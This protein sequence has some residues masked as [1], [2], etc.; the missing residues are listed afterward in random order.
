M[1]NQE[2]IFNEVEERKGPVACESCGRILTHPV[3]IS[4][5]LGPICYGIPVKT[6]NKIRISKPLSEKKISSYRGPVVDEKIAGIVKTLGGMLMQKVSDEDSKNMIL[7]LIGG[8][9]SKIGFDTMII[10]DDIKKLDELIEKE[11][12]TKDKIVIGYMRNLCSYA[13]FD[14]IENKW[15]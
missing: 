10:F 1:S 2:A 5:G 9:V 3:S 8:V 13:G 4:R 14:D 7:S 12:W 6:S 11:K 15:R